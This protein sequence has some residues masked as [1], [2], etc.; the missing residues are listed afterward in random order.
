MSS[1]DD[2]SRENSPTS[3]PASRTSSRGSSRGPSSRRPPQGPANIIEFVDSQDP[4]VKSAIQR[5]TAYHSAAQRR[6]ARLRSLRRGGS[7]RF[8]EW[9]RRPVSEPP[10]TSPTAGSPTTS[11]SLASLTRTQTGS[12]FEDTPTRLRAPSFSSAPG[13]R[14][15]SPQVPVSAQEEAVLNQCKS[16]HLRIIDNMLN[17][18]VL[19]N[20]C[21]QSTTDPVQS[22]IIIF[23]RSDEACT[24]LLLAYSYAISA[25]RRPD[26]ES[27]QRDLQIAQRYF[28]RGTNLL[29]N[30]LRDPRNAS[31]DVNIQAVLLLVAYASDFGNQNEVEI[32]ADALR[33]MVAQRRGSSAITNSILR[34]QLESIEA[35]RRF[36]LTLGFIHDCNAPPRF[37]NGFWRA[38][39]SGEGT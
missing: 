12:S 34:S 16:Q 4:N 26:S 13:S 27:A 38:S 2:K 7:S 33:T 5:H 39:R 28:G 9:G 3:G 32:H 19:Q 29:W 20:L 1:G 8:L 14:S 11:T 25:T 18:A 22:A 17:K 30:R 6:D 35:T 15:I 23:I 31:S 10:A 36:H 37:P 21:R 24:Q